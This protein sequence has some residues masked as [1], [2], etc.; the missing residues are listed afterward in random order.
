MQD[1]TYNFE[2]STLIAQFADAFNEVVIKRYS[3]SNK[4]NNPIQKGEDIG[5]TFLYS[6]KQRVIHDFNNNQAKLELPVVCFSI[7]GISRDQ[8]RVFNKIQ[9]P[10]FGSG[11]RSSYYDAKQPLPVDLDIS[12]TLISRYQEDMDQLITNFAPYCDPYVVVSWPN[13]YVPEEEIRTHII[14][15]GSIKLD[16]P[17]ELKHNDHFLVTGDA[18]FTIKGWLFKKEDNDFNGIIHNINTSFF[19]VSN[20]YC[21]YS[22]NVGNETP[23]NTDTLYISGQPVIT[24][25]MPYVYPIHEQPVI[26]IQGSMFNFT[27]SFYVSGDMFESTFQDFTSSYYASAYFSFVPE[28]SGYGFYGVQVDPTILSNDIVQFSV[29]AVSSTGFFDI[30]AVNDAGVGYLTQDSLIYPLTSSE[31]TPWQKPCVNGVQVISSY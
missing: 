31:F 13:P 3:R 20:I 8:D 15:D 1:Y 2:I 22:F 17:T 27:S 11:E 5:V 16:Y 14:W 28:E 6:P 30:I 29:P 18:S 23:E 26:T 9:G 4:F 21:N 10:D 25:V 24:D 7:N 19:A 12:L